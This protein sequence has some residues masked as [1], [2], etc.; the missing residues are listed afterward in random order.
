MSQDLTKPPKGSKFRMLAPEQFGWGT[1]ESEITV[2]VDWTL[3]TGAHAEFSPIRIRR[4]EKRKKYGVFE[5][6]AWADTPISE[7]TPEPAVVNS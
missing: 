5:K 1:I 3:K 6:Y 7:S 2:I 4:K